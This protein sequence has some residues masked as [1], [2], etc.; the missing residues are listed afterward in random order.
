MKKNVFAAKAVR[1]FAGM[2]INDQ[3]QQLVNYIYGHGPN[4]FAQLWQAYRGRI[5]RALFYKFA[6]FLK[7]DGYMLTIEAGA[8][9]DIAIAIQGATVR[10]SVILAAP[11]LKAWAPVMPVRVHIV[12]ARRVVSLDLDPNTANMYIHGLISWRQ[13]CREKMIKN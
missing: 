13:V 2:A 10:E 6:D 7:T 4:R 9:G 3:E 5:S 1:I 8:A 11:I 12:G